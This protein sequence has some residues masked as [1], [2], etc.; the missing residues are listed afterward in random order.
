M[1]ALAQTVMTEA[2]LLLI[3]E[4]SLGLA[5]QM[6]AVL[7]EVVAGMR[8]EGRSVL[9]SASATSAS[10]MAALKRRLRARLART[11][12]PST[13]HWHCP[14]RG[15]A[16]WEPALLWSGIKGIAS[17]SCDVFADALM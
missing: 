9:R 11:G 16:A 17:R 4:A 10:S 8:D 7:F 1:L 15:W 3:D 14:G 13:V 6:V 2:G 5:P 12:S